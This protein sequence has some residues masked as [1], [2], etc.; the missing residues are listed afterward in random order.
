MNKTFILLHY[1]SKEDWYVCVESISAIRCN[2][3]K[4]DSNDNGVWIYLNGDS[5]PIKVTET[6]EEVQERIKEIATL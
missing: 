6:F 1:T 5:Q 3:D 2:H 4:E